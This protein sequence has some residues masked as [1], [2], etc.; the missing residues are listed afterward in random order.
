MLTEEYIEY[1]RTVRRY[2]PRTQEIYSSVLAE[3]AEHCGCVGEDTL[4]V[5]SLVPSIIR[6][7]EVHLVED[8]GLD[9]RTVNM[10]LSVLSGFCRHLMKTGVLTNN[11]VRTVKRPKMEKRLPVFYREDAMNDYFD[12]TAHAVSEENLE[13]ITGRDKV[14]LEVYSQRLSRLVVSILYCAGIRRSELA[15]LNVGSVDFGRNV[16]HVHGKGDKD[17]EI[18]LIP[19]LCKEI[20]LYLKSVAAIGLCL[21]APDDPLLVTPGGA[22]L[23][24]VF[25]DRTVKNELGKNADVT[26]RKSPHVLRHSLATGLLNSGTDLNSIKE[27][28]GHSSL[29][30]TQVYT[31][32]SVEK[33]KNV[34]LNAH[35][36]AKSG[37]KNGD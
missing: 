19:S 17:R 18:P 14:S 21:E 5:Q 32:N 12:R 31:H 23:Y 9:S 13:L 27:L 24:P 34:Y 36:R 16:L 8:R 33:L 15:G 25:I 4:L 2:S 10:H 37:G 26:G 29:A 30:A 22:R 28:L 11:P 3:F 35:P 6:S 20:S 7:Y 1:I